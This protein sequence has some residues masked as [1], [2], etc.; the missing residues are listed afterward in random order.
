MSSAAVPEPIPALDTMHPFTTAQALAAGIDPSRLRRREFRRLAKGKYVSS[1]RRPSALLDAQAALLGHPPSAM[2]THT[3]AARVYGMPV[4]HDVNLHVGV[5]DPLDRRRR[6]GVHSHVVART[7]RVLEHRDVRIAAPADVY[8]QLAAMLP[9][10]E[11]VVV[12]DYIVRQGWHSPDDLVR[13]CAASEE[14]HAGEALAAARYVRE[15][16]D[17]PME[18]RLRMLLVLAGFP[19]PLVNFKLRDTFGAVIRRFDLYYADVRVLVEYDGRQ[20]AE[21]PD[22]YD[23]DIYRRE[24][25]DDGEWRI[26][27]VT[28]KGIYAR[29]EETLQRAARCSGP[30]KWPACHVVSTPSGVDTSP[31]R[32]PASAVAQSADRRTTLAD[33]RTTLGRRGFR[34]H[35][36]KRRR[37][38][39]SACGCRARGRKRAP[40][41]P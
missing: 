32:R 37:S 39:P 13:L 17:S 40:N 12:G 30:V 16:V 25:L 1:Q 9:L 24:E 11:L 34:P 2:A 22:Q 18:S 19:E 8:V 7:T 31:A 4:P 27:V 14:A 10:V 35:G 3:T 5:T 6:K 15:G 23:H 33:R 26:V 29:P 38:G 21:D 41:H 28:A 20:H 36:R